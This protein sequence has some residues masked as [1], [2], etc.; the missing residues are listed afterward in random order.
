M[1]L[2]KTW[3]QRSQSNWV[4]SGDK[5]LDFFHE[6]AS[7]RRQKNSVLWLMDESNQWQ[8]DPEV[9]RNIA[10]NY[11]QNL[12]STSHNVIQEEILQSIDARVS[13]PMNALLVREFQLVEVR[14]A[15]KQMHPMKVP[16]SNS[17]NPLS[18]QY[19]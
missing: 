1:L 10:V 12:F 19:F 9:V 8:E 15:L 18:Y 3:D 13:E 11:Y 5:T 17:M 4:K 14:K 6:K 7:S 16:R 2:R